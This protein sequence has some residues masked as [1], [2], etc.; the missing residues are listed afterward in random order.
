VWVGVGVGIGELEVGFGFGLCLW[1]RFRAEGDALGDGAA[2]GAWLVARGAY[3]A[4]RLVAPLARPGQGAV[5]ESCRAATADLC[6][7]RA[8][9]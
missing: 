6:C 8:T 2:L 3:E 1:I 5:A 9:P 4:Q 7:T